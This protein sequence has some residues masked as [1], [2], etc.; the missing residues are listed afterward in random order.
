MS[1]FFVGGS[2]S[3]STDLL[4]ELLCRAPSTEAM[5]QHANYLRM[6]L[7][8]YRL[9]KQDFRDG[10]EAYFENFADYRRFNADTFQRFIHYCGNRRPGIKHLVAPGPQLTVLFPEIF[11]LLPQ[12]RFVLVVRDPRD[13]VASLL[14]AGSALQQKGVHSIFQRRS[15]HQLCQYVRSFYLPALKCRQ[16]GFRE[17]MTVVRYEDVSRRPQAILT[18]LRAFTGLDLPVDGPAA[19]SGLSKRAPA[20]ARQAVNAGA[21]LSNTA[22]GY[23]QQVLSRREASAIALE[24]HEFF[25][26]FGYA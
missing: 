13:V 3:S 1:I 12:A 6:L 2:L 18:Q 7:D 8:A 24:M 15:M 23:H 14:E 11:E 9:G 10:G 5:P 4:R 20:K 22:I 16:A 25:A 26:T 19:A 17:R 21:A